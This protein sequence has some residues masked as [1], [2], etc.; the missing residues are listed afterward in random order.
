VSSPRTHA[1]RFRIWQHCRELEWNTTTSAVADALG[2]NRRTVSKVIADAGW[3]HRFRSTKLDFSG[4][5]APGDFLGS[6]TVL[7]TDFD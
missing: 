6:V 1:L 3:R 4:F 5:G 7:S 2:E